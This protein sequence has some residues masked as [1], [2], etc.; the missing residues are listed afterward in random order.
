MA[1]QT[2]ASWAD[3]RMVIERLRGAVLALRA[4]AT[5]AVWVT[6]EDGQ[7]R[8][9]RTLRVDLDGTVVVVFDDHIL[10][11][12]ALGTGDYRDQR[13]GL[14]HLVKLVDVSPLH[15]LRDVVDG[16]PSRIR[17]AV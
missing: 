14:G 4:P 9:L 2:T 7:T 11:H 12:V 17:V 3:L 16:R 6:E 15:P 10:A 8:G 5:F 1:Q 13:G